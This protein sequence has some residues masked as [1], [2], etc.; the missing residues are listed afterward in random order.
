MVD[1]LLTKREG[2]PEGYFIQVSCMRR[3]CLKHVLGH[4]NTTMKT[5]CKLNFEDLN[6][7]FLFGPDQD[8]SMEKA[9]KTNQMARH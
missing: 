1:D 3:Y 2:G 6:Q 5:L 8:K 7:Q 9:K 4:N